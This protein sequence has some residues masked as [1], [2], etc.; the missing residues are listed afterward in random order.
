MNVIEETRGK[1]LLLRILEPRLD[2]AWAPGLRSELIRRVDEGHTRLVLD[3]S[4]VDFMDSSGLSSLIS[5]LK[6]IG[7]RGSIAIAGA[8]GD[9]ARLFSLTRMDRV[10]SIQSDVEAAL[11]QAGA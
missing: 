2:A 1:V 4:A 9:V 10:F 8:K 7:A 5:C 11:A 3:L 6:H